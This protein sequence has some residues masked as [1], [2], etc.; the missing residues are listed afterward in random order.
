MK[1]RTVFYCTECGNETARW[2]G[3][4]PACG[5]WNTLTEAPQR[6]KSENKA[7]AAAHRARQAPEKLADLDTEEE[8]RFSTGVG[9]LHRVLGG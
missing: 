1:Q 7:A 3:Q 2:Q 4:C 5:A 6:P 9:E 8:I